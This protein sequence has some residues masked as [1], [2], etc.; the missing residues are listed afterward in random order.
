MLS[1]EVLLLPEI[2]SKINLSK[3]PF[4][5]HRE[6]VTSDDFIIPTG[7]GIAELSGPCCWLLSA[8][9]IQLLSLFVNLSLNVVPAHQ[10]MNPACPS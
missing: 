8:V 3:Q 4:K 5:Y 2:V 7:A 6:W 1:T 10:L 9:V